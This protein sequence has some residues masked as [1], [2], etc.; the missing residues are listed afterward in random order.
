MQFSRFLHNE[1]VTVGEM[2]QTAIARTK[3][4]VVGREILVIQDS[5][6]LVF[7]GKKIRARGFGP[8]GK[9]G[10]LSGLLLHLPL[11]V[12]A[13]NGA[14]LGPVDIQ[15]FN[16]PPGRPAPRRKRPTSQK[17]SQRWIDGMMKAAEL[18]QAA[19]ITV[20]ADRE[21]D[22][23][24]EFACRPAHVHLITRVAQGHRLVRKPQQEGVQGDRKEQALSAF[25]DAL[26]EQ[27]RFT[28]T[29]PAAPG[30]QERESELILRY[31]TIELCKPRNGAAAD[32]PK[33][34]SLTVVD[35]REASKPAQGE[36]LHWCLLTTHTVEN[37]KNARMIIDFYRRR[38]TI[39]EYFHTLKTAGFDIEAAQLEDPEAMAR[40][41][42][43]AACAAVTVMQLLRARDGRSDQALEEVFETED[44]PLLEAISAQH[45]GK[46]ARQKN[47]HPKRSL[48]YATWVVARLGCWDGYYGKP[49]PLVLRRGL[50]D[51]HRIKYGYD[52]RLQHV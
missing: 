3:R 6:E 22:I 46:T 39:E 20:V 2:A 36:A 34:V 43:A 18:S 1:A 45:E 8:V 50:Q 4:A 24:E 42:G 12:D 37:V 31:S 44:I 19:S 35:V 14:V 30:R 41:V 51:F 29:I 48:A 21:S 26:P 13:M 38:W 33:T 27:G 52:L 23:Y 11:A 17:E 5:S 28:T 32:L 16:R 15:V 9:G 10:N 7:G 47:P 40:L 49:G 25:V